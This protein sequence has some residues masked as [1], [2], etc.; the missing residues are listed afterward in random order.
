M[1]FYKGFIDMKRIL[2]SAIACFAVACC[3]CCAEEAAERDVISSTDDLHGKTVSVLSGS[4]QDLF[5]SQ[6]L[7]D[8][9]IMRSDSEID[10]FT[11]VETDK[12][13]GTI[14]SDIVWAMVGKDFHSSIALSEK[15][16]PMPI[17][18]CFKKSDTELRERF[19]AFLKD[20]VSENDIDS[21]IEDWKN[22][23]S[24]RKMPDPSD[25][26]DP[27]GTFTFAVCSISPPFTFIR[28]GVISGVEVEMLAKF[29]ISENMRWEFM[30]V[31]FSGIINCVQSGKAD[32]AASIM[33]ITPERQQSVDFS[34]PWIEESSVLVV[35]K[36]YAPSDL[37]SDETADETDLWQSINNSLEKNLVKEDRYMLLL[38]GLKTTIIISLLAALIGTLLGA[39]LCFTS[40]HRN[41]IVSGISNIFIEFMRCMPQVVLLMIMFYIVFGSSNIDGMWV[42]IISFSLCFAAYTSVIFRSAVQSID[43]GQTEASL[44]MGFGKVRA[45][46]NIILPQTI[47]RALPVYKGEFIGLVKATSIVGYIA[48]FDLTKAGDIIRSRTYEAF[49][50]LILVTV[51][52]FLVIWALTATLKYVEAK[53][54]PKR[55]KFFK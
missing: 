52:Y 51:F 18:V 46:L 10:A 28:N 48:V 12:A 36:R 30:D 55:K 26:K 43:K 34:D 7:K 50:P 45:F 19:N 21:I 27:K 29:A 17:G 49:F 6:N 2:K 13:C 24:T 32:I 5:V 53:T 22:P 39:L 31:V 4:V 14:T 25:V 44:S 38:N 41:R 15:I 23:E 11:M 8:C 42:A 54:Q 3:C 40:M 47:Q 1:I 9:T 33:C 35:N 16:N 37:L 20:Y